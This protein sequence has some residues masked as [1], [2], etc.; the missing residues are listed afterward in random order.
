MYEVIDKLKNSEKLSHKEIAWVIEQLEQTKSL[1]GSL[2]STNERIL[3]Q[4]K[5]IKEYESALESCKYHAENVIDR[6]YCES[7][8]ADSIVDEVNQALGLE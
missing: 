8:D 3:N 5:I 7:M 1:N 6:G 4:Y 2:E